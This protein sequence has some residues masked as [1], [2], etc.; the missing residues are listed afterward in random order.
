LYYIGF[1]CSIG[2]INKNL[3]I[4]SKK[5]SCPGVGAPEQQD[6]IFISYN[7]D[8]ARK[9]DTPISV[10]ALYH[11]FPCFASTRRKRYGKK[12]LLSAQG[13]IV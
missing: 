6:G 2:K 13:R 12:T 11:G 3:V 10:A 7:H 4:I 5:E 1:L 8:E 9:M